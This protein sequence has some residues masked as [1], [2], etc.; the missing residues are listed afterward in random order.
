[1]KKIR[2]I[3]IFAAVL[4]FGCSA[5]QKDKE[6]FKQS[7]QNL[8]PKAQFIENKK[9]DSGIYWGEGI[10]TIINNLLG[11]ARELAKERALKDLSQKI[12]VTVKSDIEQMIQ[13]N[14]NDTS[15]PNNEQIREVFTQKVNTY[16]EIALLNT[17]DKFV[18][19]YPVKDNCTYF[20]YVSKEEY[21]RNVKEDMEKK[22]SAVKSAVE[23]GDK[24]LDK[25]DFMIA[26]NNWI[27]ANELFAN[28]FGGLPVQDDLNSDGRNEEVK[29]AIEE[30]INNLF[31]NIRLS[32]VDQKVT[33][34]AAGSLT[35][36]PI[37][38]AKYEDAGG[39]EYPVANLPLQVDFVSGKGRVKGAPKTTNYGEA[40]IP[41]KID[42]SF[43]ATE[44]N[45]KIDKNAFQGLNDF[46]LTQL[47]EA[48]LTIEKVKT[49]AV[50]V[51]FYNQNQRNTPNEL[52]SEIKGA[53]LRKGF[54]T[55]DFSGQG[56]NVNQNDIS[57]AAD[58]N[59]DYL[60]VISLNSS[61][62][63]TVGGYSN[64]YISMVSGLISLYKLPRGDQL[65][66]ETVNA[67]K[68]FGVSG[69]VAGWDAYGKIKNSVISKTRNIIET[70]R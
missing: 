48:R 62:T 45:V 10:A 41:L 23:A 58:L 22:K 61:G 4:F 24:A 57:R 21:Q 31:G 32:Y 55:V 36:Y 47:S 52:F 19:N 54:L 12:K 2:L 14:I 39:R 11:D 66:S 35:N 8:N 40:Q 3:T 27:A 28:F 43:P 63:G 26:A 56:R 42:A 34:D 46:H 29:A 17:K 60:F 37:V 1:M 6:G 59:A 49:V 18:E 51:S 20:V 68:G 70:I 44:I 15:K 5:S 25:N 64:M 65:A 67:V 16:T 9:N 13:S 33:Y 7:G 30:R 38:Q 69:S 50:A 53:L